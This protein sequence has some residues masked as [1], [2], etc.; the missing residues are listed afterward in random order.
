MKSAHLLGK[1]PT[2]L[3]LAADDI[4]ELHAAR[5]LL[6][7]QHCG[8]KNQI[9]GL[10]KLA[11]LDFF[12]RYPSFYN[13]AAMYSNNVVSQENKEGS[14]IE[15]SMVRHHYGPWDKRYYQVLAF[16]ESR[17][18]LSVAK[19]GNTYE[20]ALTNTGQAKATS[21]S[22][23]GSF[24]PLVSHMKAVKKIFGRKTGTQLKNLVYE[25]FD[26]EVKQRKLGDVIQ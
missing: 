21:L 17:G 11:K 9:D 15:S 16:L 26:A 1:E 23:E 3:P 18:L 10:T 22:R 13:R 4:T 7:I 5:L 8:S 25:I 14:S 2:S 6:L 19:R 24:R 12:V 20:F